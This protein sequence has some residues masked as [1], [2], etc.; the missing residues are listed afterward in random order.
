MN[1]TD[2]FSVRC[3]LFQLFEIVGVVASHYEWVRW[4]YIDFAL[5]K[6]NR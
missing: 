4:V 2:L 6:V 3:C 1:L 5:K